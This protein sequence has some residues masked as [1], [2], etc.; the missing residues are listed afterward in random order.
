[1]LIDTHAHLNDKQFDADRDEVLKRA[2]DA[3]VGAV[4]E[5]ADQESEW[6]RARG[7]AERHPG[8]VWWTA[9]LHPHHAGKVEKD[10]AW[11]LRDAVKHPQ[12]VAV[13]EIGLDYYRNPVPPYDQQKVFFEC[14][15]AAAESKKPLVIHCRESDA[16]SCA[17]QDDMLSVLKS[18]FTGAPGTANPP[19][20]VL[21][22]FQG[23]LDF[24]RACLEMG[25]YIG[26]DGPL[27]YPN[28][29]ALR[30]IIGEIPMDRLVLETDCPY[31][32]PQSRRG[33]RNEPSYIRETAAALAKVKD[34]SVEQVEQQTARNAEQLYR[35]GFSSA[36]SSN[37]TP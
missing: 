5:I 17:A 15:Q 21:H 9:G 18:F 13:G 14:A 22:C 32:A 12:C 29:A 10:M 30:E 35:L 1:M 7:L 28:A 27:T 3:G 8:R 11:R 25:F 4:V 23:N 26:V 31:L 2:F 33:R 37:R 24:A 16:A 34:V 20:G 6:S 19:P 36:S